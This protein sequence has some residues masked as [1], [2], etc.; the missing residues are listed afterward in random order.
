[1]KGVDIPVL[2]KNPV[3]PEIGLWIG[4][5]ERFNK[6]GI[7]KL[8]AIHRGFHNYK[9]SVYRNDPKWELPIK[10]RERVIDM[11]IICDPSHIAGKARVVEDIAQTAIDM[12]FDG[13]MIETHINPTKALSDADQ[14]ILPS[15]LN[16]I[17][18]KL[19]LKSSKLRDQKF[20]NEL[21]V[22][23]D[24]IDILDKEIIALF[25]IRKEIV[26][27]IAQLKDKNK[28]TIFQ[29][30]RWFEILKT[31]KK[32]ANN[33]NLD[34][35][36]VNEI[37]DVIHKYLILIQTKKRMIKNWIIKHADKDIINELSQTLNVSEIIAHLLT[38][39]GIQNF[40]QA[41]KFFRPKL[42]DLH[43][44]FLM[45]NMNSIKRIE[46]AIVNKE[47]ILVYGDYDVDGTTSVSMMFNFLKKQTVEVD[48]YI[49]CR[50]KEGYG[51]SLNGIDYAHN[52][53]FSL[54]IA[55][56]CGN[57]ANKQIEYA[58]T[59]Q[60]D[61]IICDHHTPSNKIPSAYSILNP[62]QMNCQYPYKHLSGCGVGFKL[63][64]AFCIYKNLPLDEAYA[65][66]DLVTVS[67]G[68]DIV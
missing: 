11:P 49:P 67:I 12:N 14:Q 51:I 28:L 10:L 1:M 53:N 62:K 64:Q 45:K 21:R 58:N 44:P 65:F 31:R 17:L 24:K 23:R 56:D 7:S 22:L 8:S 47:K 16:S 42:S 9:N 5:L 3:H 29:I 41:K 52:N 15:Q 37:F 68:A 48:Y 63:I 61:F 54:I 39:R 40:K 34:D 38:L 60:I 19:V 46:H 13:L 18:Q 33:L 27:Q 35:E 50:Y 26:E 43:D 66:L 32:Y 57:R 4:A 2:V 30:E 55:L 36:Y 25:Q 59:K 6:A 20:R